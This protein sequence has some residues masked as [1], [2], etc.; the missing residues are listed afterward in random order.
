[1]GT[2]AVGIEALSRGAARTIFLEKHHHGVHLIRENLRLL[3]LEDRATVAA[4]SAVGLLERFPGDIV[5]LDPPYTRPNEYETALSLLGENP[6][7]L[8][9]VQHDR[10]Q[11][12]RDSYGALHRTRTLTHGDNSLAFYR[13]LAEPQPGEPVIH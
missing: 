4:G 5:F 13:P 1:A 7:P 11:R 12:L 8:V 10:R 3:G 2:G 9:I 6:R